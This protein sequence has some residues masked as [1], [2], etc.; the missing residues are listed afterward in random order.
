MSKLSDVVYNSCYVLDRQGN[1]LHNYRKI[2]M[3]DTDKRYF[4]PGE[5][6]LVFE[7]VTLKGHVF[8]TAV[9]ICMDIN[10]KDFVNFYEFPLACHCRDKDVDLLL[11]PTAWT[12]RPEEETGKNSLQIGLDLYQWWK[13]RLTPM[14]RPTFRLKQTVSPRINKE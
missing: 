11:F 12:M 8:K 2:L 5:E 3:Y 1:I 13:L 4:T 14:I 10:Y 6:Y 9:G 7:L